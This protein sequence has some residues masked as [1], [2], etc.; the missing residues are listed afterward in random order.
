MQEKRAKIYSTIQK[1]VLLFILIVSFSSCKGIKSTNELEKYFTKSQIRDLNKINNF[2]ISEHL[3]S[4]RDN[5]GESY[6]KMQEFTYFNGIDALINQVG[7]KKQLKLYNSIS[8]STFDEIWEIKQN[9]DVEFSS[10]EYILPQYKGKFQS[11]L[12]YLSQTNSLAKDCWKNMEM[13]GDFY[14]LMLDYYILENFDKI[15]FNDFNN[16]IIISIYFLS[17]VD[18][19]ERDENTKKRR[20]ELQKKIKKTV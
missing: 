5:Y 1:I 16:Q 4:T 7:F 8:K 13:S 15:D 6:K 18:N 2:F 11:Y 3:N 17:L 20:L 19:N 10:E 9:T 14:H 12:K